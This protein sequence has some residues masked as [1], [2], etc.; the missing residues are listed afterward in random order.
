MSA[1]GSVLNARDLLALA[2]TRLS[3][4]TTTGR[5]CA[6][7]RDRGVLKVSGE[8]LALLFLLVLSF[9]ERVDVIRVRRQPTKRAF[10]SATV[11]CALRSF[12]RSCLK[13]TSAHRAL[14]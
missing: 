9:G 11:V 10:N 4:R 7:G 2:G 3:V 12:S 13:A 8:S 1:S 5:F 6:G 14:H